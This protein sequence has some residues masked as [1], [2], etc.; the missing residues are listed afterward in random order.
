[1]DRDKLIIGSDRTLKLAR[2]GKIKKMYLASNAPEE[3]RAEV[4]ILSKTLGIEVVY[5]EENSKQFGVRIG[6]PFT[7]LLAGESK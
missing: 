4:E 1:M 3:L 2:Q 7:V 5:L 6:K